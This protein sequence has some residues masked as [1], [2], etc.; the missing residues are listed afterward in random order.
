MH[1]LVRTG[2]VTLAGTVVLGT[3]GVAI[4]GTAQA[5]DRDTVAKREDTSTTWVQSTNL[6]DDPEDDD[7]AKAGQAD[8][9]TNHTV[10]TKNTAPTKNTAN[11]KNTAPTKNTAKTVNTAPTKN[12]APTTSTS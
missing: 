9:P 2:I 6:D 7:Q 10:N 1:K 4:A 12:T 11:T 8:S 5:D 3:A